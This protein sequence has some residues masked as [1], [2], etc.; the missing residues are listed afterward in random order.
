MNNIAL[1]VIEWPAWAKL[2]SQSTTYPRAYVDTAVGMGVDRAHL[3]AIAH[4]DP[5]RLN[6]P[7]G[8]MS[9]QDICRICHAI[10]S[11]THNASFGFIAGRQ[12]PLTAHGS[13]GYALMCAATPREA[14]DILQRFWHLRGHGVL[15]NVEE[16]DN[17]LLLELVTGFMLPAP[18]HDLFFSAI[19]TGMYL[20]LTT[21]VP[22]LPDTI[23]LWLAG[24]RP[25]NFGDYQN[26]LPVVQFNQSH[27][28]V[29]IQGDLTLLEQPLPTANP[30]ALAQA[31]A[32]CEQESALMNRQDDILQRTR[33]VLRLTSSGYL[34]LAEVAE[35][36]YLTP[37]TLRRH[38]QDSGYSYQQ[39]LEEARKR[40]S[41]ML[42]ANP[43][44][45]I[46]KVA[47]LLGYTN[48]A[49]FTRAFKTWMGV[50]PS[51]W[52]SQQ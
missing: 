26:T 35:Q 42:L 25:D 14:I 18:Y 29:F 31:L 52:R 40:D 32:M 49:N 13:L 6:D 44:V 8:K 34:S 33:K 30:E 39:L 50:T 28:G 16:T 20:G 7:A 24:R 9:L 38:L 15:L 10:L 46:Q 3:L 21:L 37:R 19:L 47:G 5:A 27:T 17:S 41:C 2:P 51:T 4:I 23:E 22:H 43:Q 11:L 48:P 1:D 45:E 12:L 36:L